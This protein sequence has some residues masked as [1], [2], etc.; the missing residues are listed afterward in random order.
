MTQLHLGTKIKPLWNPVPKQLLTWNVGRVVSTAQVLSEFE[1]L[2]CSRSIPNARYRAGVLKN[3]HFVECIKYYVYIYY[4]YVYHIITQLTVSLTHNSTQLLF[5]N[6]IVCHSCDVSKSKNLFS[7]E[8][9]QMNS[10]FTVVFLQNS[11]V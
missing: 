1:H 5:L 3:S 2:S 4:T 9:F 8:D 11:K 7:T 10:G 6:V